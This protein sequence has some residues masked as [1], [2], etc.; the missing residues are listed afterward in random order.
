MYIFEK[1]VLINCTIEKAFRFHSD[2][3]NLAKISPD[4]IKVR[5]M[6]LD[7]PVKE[8][9]HIIL[10][11]RQFGFL[12]TVWELVIKNYRENYLITDKLIKGPFKFWEHDHIFEDREGK[13][14]MTDRLKYEIPFGIFGK[15]AHSI[16]IKSQIEEQFRLRHE[17]TKAVLEEK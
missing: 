12:S 13:T 3:N 6:Q 4:N 1:S 17:K 7:L 10:K 14:L 5:I 8:G 2:T 15:A 16:F 9:S 11:I